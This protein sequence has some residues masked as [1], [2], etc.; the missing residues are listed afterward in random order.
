MGL[1]LAKI[2]KGEF[3]ASQEDYIKDKEGVDGGKH[4]KVPMNKDAHPAPDVPTPELVN[5]AQKLVGELMWLS[6]RTRPDISYASSRC[7]Q[8]ILIHPAW[9]IEQATQVWKYLNT[10]NEGLKFE[11]EKG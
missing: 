8:E 11:K 4:I 1:E 10:P 3:I 9:V 5:K 7:A 2:S 6:T